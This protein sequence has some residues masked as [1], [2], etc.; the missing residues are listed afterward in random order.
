MNLSGVAIALR[1]KLLNKVEKDP[2]QADTEIWFWDKNK[3]EA[4]EPVKI[5]V[6]DFP[7]ANWVPGTKTDPTPKK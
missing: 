1:H 2:T 3:P 4:K 7:P 5:K 6:K